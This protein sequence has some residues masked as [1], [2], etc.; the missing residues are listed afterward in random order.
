[1]STPR[2]RPW[3]RRLARVT[4]FLLLLA[5]CLLLLEVGTRLVLSA[6]GMHFAIEMWKYA[7]TVKRP[8]AVAAMAHE[9]A[10]HAQAFL[11]GADVRISGQGLRDRE[12]TPTPDSDAYRILVLGDSVTFG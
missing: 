1:M 2:K 10:P 7:R 8:S 3:K 9:H 5:L 12:Y 4:A 11:M 6:H